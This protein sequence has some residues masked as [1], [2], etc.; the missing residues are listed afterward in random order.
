M[1]TLRRVRRLKLRAI[2]AQRRITD[3]VSTRYVPGQFGCNVWGQ[4]VDDRQVDEQFG[5]YGTASAVVLL[6]A[7]GYPSD[8]PLLAPTVRCLEALYDPSGATVFDRGDLD[9]TYKSIFVALAT[10]PDDAEIPMTLP[11]LAKLRSSMVDDRGWGQHTYQPHP[12]PNPHPLATALALLALARCRDFR[13]SE[14]CRKSTRWLAD[15]VNRDDALQVVIVAI[16]VVALCRYND[17]DTSL[18]SVLTDI[19]AAV[20]RLDSWA[21]GQAKGQ[22][23]SDAGLYYWVPHGSDQRNHYLN[24]PQDVIV[25]LAL[26]SAGKPES[27]RSYVLDVGMHVVHNVERHQSYQSA[28]RQRSATSDQL[29]VYWFLEKLQEAATKPEQLVSKAY[30]YVSSTRA[31]RFWTGLVLVILAL[32]SSY[33]SVDDPGGVQV[34]GLVLAGLSL[35]VLAALLLSWVGGGKD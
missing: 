12:D 19:R 20:S 22:L 28:N 29:W 21:A 32:G 24:F 31:K 11:P 5:I 9:I 23:G 13:S 34:V 17:A 18:P 10:Q 4:F 16:A 14:A 25:A 27:S 33:F 26:L 15:R 30:A 3:T 1:H 35:S 6:S 8:N 2:A 7:S